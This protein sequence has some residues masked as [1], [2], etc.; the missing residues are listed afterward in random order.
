MLIILLTKFS[1]I[2][3]VGETKMLYLCKTRF[4]GEDEKGTP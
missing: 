2:N 4:L 3:L 1:R